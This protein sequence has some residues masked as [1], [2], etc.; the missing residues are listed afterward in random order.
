MTNVHVDSD[1]S[2]YLDGELAPADRARVG[3]HL[4]GC[5][6]CRARL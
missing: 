3:A 4:D 1:L 2:A 6:R 5:D